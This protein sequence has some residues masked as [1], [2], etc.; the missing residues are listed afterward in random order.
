MYRMKGKDLLAAFCEHKY[1]QIRFS[2]GLTVSV[3]C[4]VLKY[5]LSGFVK[6]WDQE[7]EAVS[8][9]PIS[10]DEY[11]STKAPFIRTQTA[12]ND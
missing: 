2:S 12:T 1:I 4:G 10:F 3:N 5:Y 11:I 7:S 9:K 6:Q 8:Y